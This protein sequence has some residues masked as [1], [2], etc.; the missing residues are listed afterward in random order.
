[1]IWNSFDYLH[2]NICADILARLGYRLDPNRGNY[3]VNIVSKEQ[4]RIQNFEFMCQNTSTIFLKHK[5]N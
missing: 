2:S 1:M 5:S 4:W 3:F